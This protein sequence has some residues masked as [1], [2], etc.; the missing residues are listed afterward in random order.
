MFSWV[1]GSAE[2]AAER[3][4]FAEQQT[5]PGATPADEAATAAATEAAQ[6][7]GAPARRRR[8]RIT[9][10]RTADAMPKPHGAPVDKTGESIYTYVPDAEEAYPLPYGS[11]GAHKVYDYGGDSYSYEPDEPEIKGDEDNGED[12]ETDLDEERGDVLW[13]QIDNCPA[14]CQKNVNGDDLSECSKDAWK[15]CKAISNRPGIGAGIVRNRLWQHF[16][17]SGKHKDLWRDIGEDAIKNLV[18][19]A[20]VRVTVSTAAERAADRAHWRAQEEAKKMNDEKKRGSWEP[21]RSKSKGAGKG[22]RNRGSSSRGGAAAASSGV[23]RKRSRS[24]AAEQIVPMQRALREAR[25]PAEVPV[26]RQLRSD[27]LDLSVR[28]SQKKIK[29][30][31]T[32]LCALQDHIGRTVQTIA[33]TQQQ[34]LQSATAL[35]GQN[36]ILASVH[37][38][39]GGIIRRVREE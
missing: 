33:S 23:I 10:V 24:R 3:P 31:L 28:D 17:H 13:Y 15:K 29:M 2:P 8:G 20:P 39:L 38:S 1:F 9:V 5:L 32:E 35:Q 7:A 37:E 22:D 34:L 18:K 21:S 26:P 25:T 30:S 6:P 14:W 12:P 16:C 19:S 4:A 11:D 36:E 27:G